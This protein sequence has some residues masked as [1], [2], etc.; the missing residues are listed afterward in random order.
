MA[1][2][3]KAA[4]SLLEL[5]VVIAIAALLLALGVGAYARY[6]S[7]TRLVQSSQRLAAEITNLQTQAR[8]F[9]Q[10]QVRAGVELVNVA[11]ATASNGTG[12]IEARIFE[13]STTALRPVKRF[14]LCDDDRYELE[15]YATNVCDQPLVANDLGLILEV[16]YTRSGRGPYT[17]LFTLPLQPDGS[18]LLPSDQE[19]ARIV[20]FNGVYRRIIEVSRVGKVKESRL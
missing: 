18:I 7:N 13:G 19:P 14:W 15:I 8:A 16:G 5:L 6:R 20:L 12:S 10:P 2:M 1:G 11:N 3:R 4:F 17:R 9:G